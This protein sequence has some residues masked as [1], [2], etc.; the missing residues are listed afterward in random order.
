MSFVD[1]LLLL[2]FVA[3][4]S[5]A[6]TVTGFAF[7]LILMGSVALLDIAP[8]PMVA[9]LISML[10]LFNCITALYRNTG[11]LNWEIIG[12]CSASGFLA[13]VLGVWA[14]N[15]LSVRYVATLKTVLGVAII[16]SSLLL[17]FRP[18]PQLHRSGRL[19]FLAFGGLSGFMG[20]MFSTSG[21]PLVFHFYRQPLSQAMIRDTLL[22]IFTI[23]SVQ[24]LVVVGVQGAIE[25]R[26]LL[27]AATAI[28][29]VLAFTWVG[30]HYPPPLS[31]RA[32]RR[33]AF[34]LLLLSGLSLCLS[35]LIGAQ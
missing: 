10:S 25:A 1:T 4:A 31:D 5:Y 35:A 24:R 27:I 14:L 29:V 20:G 9:I 21:P 30:K 13:L 26:V 2:L 22:A 32:M 23:N 8:I 19:S 33:V 7:G 16:I 6:Q 28:P 17:I 11:N 15:V 12:L 18:A 3:V 34:V